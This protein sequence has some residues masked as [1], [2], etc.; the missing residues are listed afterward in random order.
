MESQKRAKRGTPR[1]QPRRTNDSIIA[2]MR[3]ERGWTQKELAARIGCKQ[4]Q[5]AYWESKKSNPTFA[6]LQKLAN[7]FGCTIAELMA[8]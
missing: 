1:P 2:R 7:A 8:D 4:N 6:S 3:L 5:I